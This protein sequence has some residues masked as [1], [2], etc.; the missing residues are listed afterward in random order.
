MKVSH[1]ES[2][3]LILN[4]YLCCSPYVRQGSSAAEEKDRNLLDNAGVLPAL[5]TASFAQCLKESLAS[6][7]DICVYK[8]TN[9]FPDW[10]FLEHYNLE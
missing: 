1:E 8:G 5:G 10:D 6:C 4:L 2:L 3:T 9:A 7:F